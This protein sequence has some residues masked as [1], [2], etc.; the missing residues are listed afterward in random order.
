MIEYGILGNEQKHSKINVIFFPLET[1]YFETIKNIAKIFAAFFLFHIRK[2]TTDRQMRVGWELTLI[3]HN[4]PEYLSAA[5]VW[6]TVIL[7][8][9]L[10]SHY[11]CN[12]WLYSFHNIVNRCCNWNIRKH[13]WAGTAAFTTH[14]NIIVIGNQASLKLHPMWQ[15]KD[16]TEQGSARRHILRISFSPERHP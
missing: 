11:N 4:A 5:K 7:V 10:Y 15:L 12:H 2:T 16:R 9:L 14:Q 6:T 13:C 3:V 8:S 1:Q